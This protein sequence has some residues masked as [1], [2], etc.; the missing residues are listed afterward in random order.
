[1]QGKGTFNAFAKDNSFL[2]ELFVDCE[3]QPLHN[4]ETHDEEDNM[5]EFIEPEDPHATEVLANKRARVKR[6]ADDPDYV[7]SAEVQNRA[8]RN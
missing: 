1:M 5:D 3:E 2:H 6:L 4:E 8:P 7:P